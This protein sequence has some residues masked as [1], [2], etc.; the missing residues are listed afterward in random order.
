[1][2]GKEAKSLK[3]QINTEWIYPPTAGPTRTEVFAAA[4]PRRVV[5][6]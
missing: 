1:M 6:A 3:T 5:V 4:D 2:V